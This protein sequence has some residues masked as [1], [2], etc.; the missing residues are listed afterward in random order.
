MTPV[1]L[2]F[3]IL[4]LLT[5]RDLQYD[6]RLDGR[7]VLKMASLKTVQFALGGGLDFCVL[8]E[9]TGTSILRS[10]LVVCSEYGCHTM[11]WKWKV[12]SLHFHRCCEDKPW[13]ICC[14]THFGI[15]GRGEVVTY[16]SRSD[17]SP[18]NVL[19]LMH[20]IWFVLSILRRMTRKLWAE[21]Q[22]SLAFFPF[23]KVHSVLR[24]SVIFKRG[25]ASTF[26]TR[27]RFGVVLTRFSSLVMHGTS[28]LVVQWGCSRSKFWNR[29]CHF[30]WEEF[31][32]ICGA[33]GILFPRRKRGSVH[34]ARRK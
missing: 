17:T 18:T 8:T 13:L 20:L 3:H 28:H 9:L 25:N 19:L 15:S 6:Y 14:H 31:S 26:R 34:W 32:T 11:T 30:H 24:I 2:A 10:C 1:P 7:R 5:D 22:S 29:T 33:F 27:F 12:G 4:W 21:C 16:R 23:E